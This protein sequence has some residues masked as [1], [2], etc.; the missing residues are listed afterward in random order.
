[1]AD[2]ER[3]RPCGN[4][5]SGDH[6]MKTSSFVSPIL[7]AMLC[8]HFL[9]SSDEY[10]RNEHECSAKPH[11]QSCGEHRRIHKPVSHPCDDPEFDKDDDNGNP[12]GKLKLLDKEREGVTNASPA[13]SWRRKLDRVPR[14][15]R[16][17]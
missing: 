9:R 17:P 3:V 10:A 4:F 7:G 11:L 15:V 12:Q 6:P 8:G 14:D 13:S 2:I 16:V 5:R 1:M